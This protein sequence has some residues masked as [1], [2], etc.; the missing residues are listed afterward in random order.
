MAIEI[1]DE[2]IG[3]IRRLGEAEYPYE[4]CGLLLG[5]TD[6]NGLKKVSRILPVINAKDD[7]ERHNRSLITPQELIRGE[8]MA[9]ELGL[10][11]V[12]NFHSHPDH[13]AVPSA[14]DLEHALPVWS[15]II[16]SVSGSSAGDV[17]SWVMLDDRSRFEEEELDITSRGP[18]ALIGEAVEQGGKI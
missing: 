10:D 8:R 17:R 2:Q 16:V 7:S 13:P 12:G 18:A 11:V 15:Y 6:G 1:N 14:F 9:S 4:A 3:E 5:V